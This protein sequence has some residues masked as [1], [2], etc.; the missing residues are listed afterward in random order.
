[1][2]PY[3]AFKI[4]QDYIMATP[5]HPPPAARRALR[6]LG[7][8]IRDARR[9]R[10]LPMRVVAERA[11]TSRPTLTRIER[12]D[13]SVSIGVVAAVLQALGLLER[14]AEVAD[15]AHDRV[16]QDRAAERLPQ[17]VRLRKQ[18]SPSRDHDE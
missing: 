1:M 11:S 3:L 4:Y 12:G 15:A 9:R 7:H 5:H 2:C 17:R 6:K 13:P 10:G 8:D 18:A 14:L 16:G